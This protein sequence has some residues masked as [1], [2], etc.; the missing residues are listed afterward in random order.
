MFP[1]ALSSVQIFS[2]IAVILT[3][4]KIAYHLRVNMMFVIMAAIMIV[5]PCIPQLLQPELAH[6]LCLAILVFLGLILGVAQGSVAGFAGALPEK[7]LASLLLGYG[8]SGISISFL[9]GICLYAFSEGNGS[10]SFLGIF[11]YF[12]IAALFLICSAPLYLIEK[13][14]RLI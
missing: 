10:S 13:K 1:L 4:N 5:L 2:L 11:L 7:Y 12:L 14:S 8:V 3:G 9:R 6:T